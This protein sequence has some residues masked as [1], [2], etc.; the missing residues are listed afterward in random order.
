MGGARILATP[1][2][3]FFVVLSFF[4]VGDVRNAVHSHPTTALFYLLRRYPLKAVI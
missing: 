1:A 3:R 2:S 4:L